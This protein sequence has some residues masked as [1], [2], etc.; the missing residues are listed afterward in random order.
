MVTGVSLTPALATRS[1]VPIALHWTQ[2]PTGWRST[3]RVKSRGPRSRG[4]STA[5]RFGTCEVSIR[6]MKPKELYRI[7]MPGGP[8][9]LRVE[10]GASLGEILWAGQYPEHTSNRIPTCH[11]V[12]L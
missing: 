2:K 1:R 9:V 12:T 6:T 5:R 8:L 3:I 10:L 4:V 7:E 11:T